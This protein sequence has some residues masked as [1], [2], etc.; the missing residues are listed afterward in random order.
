L[1]LNFPSNTTQPYVDPTSGIKYIFNS[2]IGAWESA[3]QPPSIVG[4]TEPAITIEGFLWWDT[5]EVQLKVYN[6]GNWVPIHPT[7]SNQ[8]D[9]GANPPGGVGNGSL[10]WDTISGR[11]Y[12]YYIDVDSAQW[13]VASPLSPPNSG[14]VTSGPNAPDPAES[15]EGDLWFNT[16]NQTLYVYTNSNWVPTQNTVSGVSSVSAG[17]YVNI[18]GTSADPIVNVQNSTTGQRGAIQLASQAVVNAGTDPNTA[19]TPATLAGGISNYLPDATET[20]RGTVELAT[21]AEVEAGIDTDRA[22][23]PAAFKAS[24]NNLGITNPAG[25]VIT[26]A[27]SSA[28]TGYLKCDGSAVDRTTFAGLFSAI[29]TVYGIGDGSTTFNLPDLRGEFVRG[30]DDGRGIDPGRGFAT[31]QNSQNLAHSHNITD[32]G[33][34]H[35]ISSSDSNVG[36]AAGAAAAGEIPSA[37]N[38]E[39]ATTGISINS[40]GGLEA[41]PRNIS[42]LYC[43]KF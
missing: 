1:A 20:T 39:S 12:I 43:I 11:M 27:G 15:A 36:V 19:I 42:L 35:E 9:V 16:L 29:G 41:R 17:T 8:V 38:S 32:P 2:A 25:T 26:F 10:W 22:I 28:P 6:N 23:T 5:T 4:A 40:S 33:H 37:N 18:S 3:I 21:Q 14:G 7:V 30:W 24:I 34:V 31:S 13:V